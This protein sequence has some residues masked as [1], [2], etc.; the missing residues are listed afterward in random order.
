[1]SKILQRYAETGSIKPGSIGGS[2]PRATT[3]QIEAKIQLYRQEYPSILCYEIRRRLLEDN[4][5]DQSNVPS[6][7][8]IARFLRGS[9]ANSP[10]KKSDSKQQLQQTGPNTTQNN[11]E[12]HLVGETRCDLNQ[13]SYQLSDETETEI[14]D[15]EVDKYLMDKNLASV[16]S[17]T[18][19][20]RLR[21]SFTAKQID[22]LE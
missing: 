18:Q 2:K 1:V 6:V 20:R 5:C 19:N 10:T 3:P 21:T 16:I 17:L 22:L 8:V 15:Q 12:R 4:V 14:H 11:C 9:N 13:D 7:S